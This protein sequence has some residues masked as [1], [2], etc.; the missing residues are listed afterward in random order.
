[1]AIIKKIWKEYK[2]DKMGVQERVVT[3]FGITIYKAMNTTTN[4]DTVRKLSTLDEAQLHIKGFN[5]SIK[6]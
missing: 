2:K 5:N 4:S 1:M 3:F 6:T